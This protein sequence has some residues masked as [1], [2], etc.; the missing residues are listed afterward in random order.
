MIIPRIIANPRGPVPPELSRLAKLFSPYSGD[1]TEVS[2]R[3]L[4][5]CAKAYQF[6]ADARDIALRM[7]ED[8]PKHVQSVMAMCRPP[9]RITYMEFPHRG[10]IETL[11]ILTEGDRGGA[12]VTLFQTFDRGAWAAPVLM[13]WLD[14]DH[15]LDSRP[16]PYCFGN[17]LTC[18]QIP[19]YFVRP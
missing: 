14:C 4:R 9:N 8:N 19:R 11:G 13:F 2:A 7:M 16:M 10:G 18:E 1:I 5:D 12:T 6:D 17:N 3:D 15:Y